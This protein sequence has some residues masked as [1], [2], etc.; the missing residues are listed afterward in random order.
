MRSSSS[1]AGPAA[2]ARPAATAKA[3]PPVWI[4]VF[5]PRLPLHA[6][7]E[8]T[9]LTAVAH[10]GS[11]RVLTPPSGAAAS[12]E[13]I[14]VHPLLGKTAT[15]KI[16]RGA[17]ELADFAFDQ[18]DGDD[19]VIV[20]PAGTPVAI[21]PPSKADAAAIAQTLVRTDA[22]AGV[23]RALAGIELGG[24]DVDGDG[25]ADLVATYGCTA[26][27]NGACQSKGQFFLARHGARWMILE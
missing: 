16:D 5:D 9:Q 12:G 15:G 6:P 25:K 21:V 22:L 10:A 27:F 17:V 20:V 14:V 3:L 19:G 18:R 1:S 23:R 7:W 11:V 2:P 26:W 4:G 13:V 24:V 8:N